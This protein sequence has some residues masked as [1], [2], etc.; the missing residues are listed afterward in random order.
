MEIIDTKKSQ[1][2]LIFSQSRDE[3]TNK[4]IDWLISLKQDYVRYNGNVSNDGEKNLEIDFEFS[5]ELKNSHPSLEYYNGRFNFRLSNLKSI[6]FRRP[7]RDSSFFYNKITSDNKVYEEYVN[8][9][10]YKFAKIL[11]DYIV[12]IL[13]DNTTKTLGSYYITGLNKPKILLTAAKIGLDIPNTL[14]TNSYNKLQSFFKSN[15]NLIINKSLEEIIDIEF[16]NKLFRSTT[17]LIDNIEQLPSD[18]FS[19][20]FFQE[21]I[22]KDYEVRSFYISG[23]IF[24]CAIFSQNNNKTKVDFR[25]HDVNNPNKIVPYN[26]PQNIKEKLSKLFNEISLNTGSIDF[27]VKGS[28]HYFLEINPIGQYDFISN[29]CNSNLDYEIAKHLIEND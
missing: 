27:V 7:N 6:F 23:R 15:N 26:L 2:H 24:S 29:Y 21:Y 3:S 12:F 8:R 16:E 4:L 11:R 13:N 25:N 28:K 20:S 14:I 19:T 1:M 10:Q 18:S 22:K 17:N 9:K 5:S